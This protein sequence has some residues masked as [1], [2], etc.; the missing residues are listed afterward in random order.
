MSEGLSKAEAAARRA[1]E[2]D[3]RS[4]QAGLLL[5]Q[6]L[7]KRGS[8]QDA[9]SLARKALSARPEAQEFQYLLAQSL[10]EQGRHLEGGDVVAL[11]LAHPPA[12]QAARQVFPGLLEAVKTA[13]HRLMYWNKFADAEKML[14][15]VR[16]HLEGDAQSWFLW[17]KLMR[18]QRRLDEAQAAYRKAVSLGPAHLLHY[19]YLGE[20]LLLQ[21]DVDGMFECFSAAAL[22]CPMPPEDD[23]DARLLRYRLAVG[24]FDFKEAGRIGDG[25]LKRSRAL[26]HVEKLMWPVIVD[27][28]DFFPRPARYLKRGLAAASRLVKAAPSSPWAAYFHLYYYAHAHWNFLPSERKVILSDCRRLKG[29]SSGAYG[30]M[31]FES[32]SYHMGLSEF[33]AAV[34]DFKTAV[35]ASEPPS[36]RAQSALAEAWFYCGDLKKALGAAAKAQTMA[37]NAA[38]R[39]E[40]FAAQAKVLLWAGEYA[41]ALEALKGISPDSSLRDFYW[42]EGGALVKLGRFPQALEV[43]ERGL[44]R[45]PEEDARVWRLEALYRTGRIDEMLVEAEAIP[46]KNVYRIALLAL[47]CAAR[48]D[49]A[50]MSGQFALL[51]PEMV[52]YV[53]QRLG[54]EPGGSEARQQAVIEGLLSLSRGVRRS[55]NQVALW[56][57]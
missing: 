4:A 6:V 46:E 43:L 52:R 5:A 51:P 37:P 54:I 2:L 47:R 57:R 32:G 38:A 16:P 27:D 1:L 49:L 39:E 17:G 21:D 9:E 45:F 20:T 50:G 7:L 40:C 56:M 23:L 53:A 44:A 35:G 30:W 22:R 25:V 29:L 36:W 24:M 10:I 15:A 55:G 26:E 28:F 41:A 48:G 8:F 11:A 33:R 19:L 14:L 31:L 34:E 12:S 13:S 42:I 3:P 18:F